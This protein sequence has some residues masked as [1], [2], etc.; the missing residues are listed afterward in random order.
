[1]LCG[2]Y[3]IPWTVQGCLTYFLAKGKEK[4]PLNFNEVYRFFLTNNVILKLVSNLTFQCSHSIQEETSSFDASTHSIQKFSLKHVSTSSLFL[5]FTHQLINFVQ[6]CTV[7]NLKCFL[8]KLVQRTGS[9]CKGWNYLEMKAF[10]AIYQALAWHQ[11]IVLT[12]SLTHNTQSHN[13]PLQI[14]VQSVAFMKMYIFGSL[15][16]GPVNPPW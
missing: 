1:M 15:F 2:T 4:F 16:R 7:I 5:H 6:F 3:H 9:L 8:H 11:A 13:T 12:G 14:C 10:I